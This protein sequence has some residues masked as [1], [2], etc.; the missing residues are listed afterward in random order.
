MGEGGTFLGLVKLREGWLTALLPSP[1]L[2]SSQQVRC[3]LAEEVWGWF[4]LFSL[5]LK[6]VPTTKSRDQRSEEEGVSGVSMCYHVGGTN[7]HV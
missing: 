7:D 6:Y 4:T 3:P 1:A 5:Q 2:M